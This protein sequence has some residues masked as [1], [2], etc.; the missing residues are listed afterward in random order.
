MANPQ[1]SLRHTD[2][3][4]LSGFKTSLICPKLKTKRQLVSE[5]LAV[6]ADDL[7]ELWCCLGWGVRV[8]ARVRVKPDKIKLLH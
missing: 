2:P 3:A 7:A 1:L 5:D 4:G 6:N 8:R